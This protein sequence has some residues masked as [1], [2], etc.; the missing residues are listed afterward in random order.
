MEAQLS[1]VVCTFLNNVED[2]EKSCSLV[3]GDDCQHL[4]S[5]RLIGQSQEGNSV[6]VP[7]LQNTQEYCYVVTATSGGTSVNVTGSFSAGME[8]AHHH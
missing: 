2:S 3:Y 4:D 6:T 8:H 5:E 7:L 1:Y